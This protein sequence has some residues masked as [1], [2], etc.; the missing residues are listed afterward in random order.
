[1]PRIRLDA[2]GLRQQPFA[3]RVGGVRDL[4]DRLDDI[5]R[6]VAQRLS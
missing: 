1:M 6:I 4:V 2:R 3:V 5:G